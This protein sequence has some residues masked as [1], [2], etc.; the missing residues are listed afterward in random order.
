MQED[1]E[2]KH[3]PGSVSFFARVPGMTKQLILKSHHNTAKKKKEE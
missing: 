3:V 1:F 2:Q